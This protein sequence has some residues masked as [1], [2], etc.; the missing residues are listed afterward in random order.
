MKKAAVVNVWIANEKSTVDDS[1]KVLLCDNKIM[2][3]K[4][5]NEDANLTLTKLCINALRFY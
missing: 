5:L 3:T 1:G 2:N 4:N